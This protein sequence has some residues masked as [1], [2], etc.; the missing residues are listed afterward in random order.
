[1]GEYTYVDYVFNLARFQNA[2]QSA[3][4]E[5]GVGN[6]AELLGVADT[7]I[8]TWISANLAKKEFPHPNMTNF[9]KVVNLLDMKPG[10]FFKLEDE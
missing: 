4:S 10:D 1:M 5:H 9:L 8:Y 6:I 2:L 3:V 7:T